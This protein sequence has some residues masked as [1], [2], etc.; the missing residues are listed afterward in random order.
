[1]IERGGRLRCPLSVRGLNSP[2]VAS[3]VG[4]VPQTLS[5]RGYGPGAQI[6][7]ITCAN[8]ELVETS[9]GYVPACSH[10]RAP[11][12]VTSARLVSAT[13]DVDWPALEHLEVAAIVT[14]AAGLVSFWNQAAVRMY[15]WTAEEAIGMSILQLTV[16]ADS[17][18][19]AGEIIREL[20][21]GYAWE[22]SWA[23]RMRS[24]GLLLVRLLDVPLLASDGQPVG[25]AGF[26]LPIADEGP[27]L[28]ALARRLGLTARFKAVR[29][30]PRDRERLASHG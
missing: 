3:C 19:R 22:G 18:G 9:Q 6:S 10:E 29:G 15:G 1:M 4:F 14:D 26:S 20:A 8:L 28:G 30:S 17:A 21:A 7:G 27:D 12:V 23:C 16:D 5:A 2:L 13:P 11:A 24:G 25:I